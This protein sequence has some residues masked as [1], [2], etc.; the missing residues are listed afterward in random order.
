MLPHRDALLLWSR[1]GVLSC[2]LQ[3]HPEVPMGAA[4]Q[5]LPRGLR[6]GRHSWPRGSRCERS[7]GSTE[8]SEQSRDLPRPCPGKGEAAGLWENVVFPSPGLPPAVGWAGSELR[9]LGKWGGSEQCG[10]FGLERGHSKISRVGSAPH[11]TA[12]GGAAAVPT[13]PG[14]TYSSRPY[15]Q[16]PAVPTAASRITAPSAARW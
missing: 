13:A 1:N 9:G 2:G 12:R 15:L 10:A 8:P 14:R 6:A 16:L 4:L 3:Q 7:E 11:L 5:P